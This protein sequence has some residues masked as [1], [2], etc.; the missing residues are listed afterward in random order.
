MASTISLQQT[1]NWAQ[2]FVSLRPLV[3]Q[4]GITN[5]PA[6]TIANTVLGFILAPPFCW[7]WNRKK[8]TVSATLNNQTYLEPVSDFG[9]LER[10]TISD[11]TTTWPLEVRLDINDTQD[12]DRPTHISAELD[13]DTGNV[14]FVL[15]PAPD[16]AY[17]VIYTY[18]KKM[19]P[20]T[21]TTSLW[22]P[23]PDEDQYLYNSGFLAYVFENADD[24]RFAMEY[25]KF[26]RSVIAASEGLN[27]TK[28]AL[29]LEEKLNE[30]RQQQNTM[31][32]AQQG[33]TA[34]GMN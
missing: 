22:S 2:S 12:Y 7:R 4:G 1:V 24:S 31:M 18:Q 28:K 26:I 15:Y 11:G 25:Q 27:D 9:F 6:L 17:T 8:G 20:L 33:R 10:A 29:F 19:V 13:D 14:T 16:K 21:S 30:L 23:I 34:R 3:G 5:E 32:G